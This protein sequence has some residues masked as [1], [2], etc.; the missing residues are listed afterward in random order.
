MNRLYIHR[1]VPIE[2]ESWVKEPLYG[3]EEKHGPA[4]I[5][6]ETNCVQWLHDSQKDD[7]WISG[8]LI[9]EYL[10]RN[11]MIGSCYGMYELQA[12]QRKGVGLFSRYFLNKAVFGWKGVVRTC[13][14]DRCVKVPFLV[15]HANN[16]TLLWLY[17]DDYFCDNNPGLRYRYHDGK[18]I[19][20]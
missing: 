20:H 19:Q 9:H 18:I 17:L 1:T 15:V 13:D 4:E 7:K 11:R 8:E 6:I 2:Y 14:I 10:V 3:E 16:V 12:I 5:N